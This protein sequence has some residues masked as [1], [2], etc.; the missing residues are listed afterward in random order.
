MKRS[1]GGEGREINEHARKDTFNASGPNAYNPPHA[2]SINFK[3]PNP[4]SPNVTTNFL[5]SRHYQIFKPKGEERN[6]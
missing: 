3:N 6:N 1:A 4:K 2:P 5:N